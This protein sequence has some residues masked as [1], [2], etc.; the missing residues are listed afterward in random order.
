MEFSGKV[1]KYIN[2]TYLEVGMELI[3]SRTGRRRRIARVGKHES[4]AAAEKFDEM[5]NADKEFTAIVNG[6]IEAGLAPNTALLLLRATRLC[7][8]I[9][10]QNIKSWF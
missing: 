4:M 6:A 10:A 5:L 9:T 8:E 7:V 2:D 3:S 1:T